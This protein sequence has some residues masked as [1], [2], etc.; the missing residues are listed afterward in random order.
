MR[1]A[2]SEGNTSRYIIGLDG[3]RAVAVLAV[4]AYH[5]LPK[6]LPGGF[7]G[8]DIFFVISGFLITS[9]LLTEHAQT[10][11]IKLRQFW[12]RRAKRLLPALL[13]V[14]GIAAAVALF[15]RG[16]I[17]VGLGRQIF[18]ALTFS[19]N[20]VEVATGANYFDADNTRLFTNFWSLAVEEQFYVVW[21]FVL[22]IF[23]SL[24]WL[25]DRPKIGM[26][27]CLGFALASALVMVMLFIQTNATRVYYGTDT[28][29]FGLM[30]GAAL[31]FWARS[32]VTDTTLR[33]LYQPFWS[34]A[35]QKLTQRL[36][37]AAGVGLL[38]LMILMSTDAPFVYYG[39]LLLASLL[40]AA[41]IVATISKRLFLQK[42]LSLAPLE[43][44]GARSYGIYLWHWP[45]WVLLSHALPIGS[46]WWT[47][48]TL[49]TI[50]TIVCATLSYRYIEM[51]IRMQG[52][53]RTM[54][55]SIKRRAVIID[56]AIVK[57][58]LQPHPIL[59]SSVI[60]ALLATTAV[61]TAPAK[62]QAQLRI[63]EGQAAIKKARQVVQKSTP[64]VFVAPITGNDITVVG[65]SVTLASATALEA[66]FPGIYI[67]AEISR[68]MRRGGIETVDTLGNA[69]LLR[70][71]VVVAL[72]TNGY[73]GAD[74]LD[75]LIAGLGDR[76]IILVTAHAPREWTVAN[77]DDEHRAAQKY[78]NVIVA[79]WDATIS[80]HPENLGDDSI[81]P[82]AA[83]GILY[84]E[85]IV[86]AL[87]KFQ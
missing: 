45:I 3:L 26:Y 16:D 29:L 7:I 76:K 42:V 40:T 18:G 19:N 74:S 71:V 72:A 65:D 15:V 64:T 38:V 58:R 32:R 48:P 77:N 14:I 24:K 37:L 80:A 79:E 10:G 81:H 34:L 56:N 25:R 66:Q 4:L 61:I 87:T 50:L 35:R 62:T 13:T 44:I 52:F 41:V 30:I 39:G 17:L 23:L 28:H 69:G 47:V 54:A 83:G 1:H 53:Q 27:M 12:L 5:L 20:W 6:V 43:W 78:K 49:T 73:F 84:A 36:G 33:R 75:Q 63:E 31:A 11:R 60:I 46:P 2:Q 21:P 70:R 57:W 22:I 86:A 68:S 59:L 55:K 51:P 8:V 9:L 67:D 85:A 82:K